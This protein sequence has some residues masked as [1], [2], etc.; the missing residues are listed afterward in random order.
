[1]R[2]RQERRRRA[3]YHQTDDTSDDNHNCADTAQ[4]ANPEPPRVSGITGESG[5]PLYHGDLQC[6]ATH[7]QYQEDPGLNDEGAIVR[8]IEYACEYKVDQEVSAV[9]DNPGNRER[10]GAGEDPHDQL[11]RCDRHPASSSTLSRPTARRRFAAIFRTSSAHGRPRPYPT[12][13]GCPRSGTIIARSLERRG[14][15][16]PK[17]TGPV[18]GRAEGS[19]PGARNCSTSGRSGQATGYA[20]WPSCGVSQLA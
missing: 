5:V 2:I 7:R 20:R 8:S 19:R 10:P 15:T 17:A 4:P 6:R 9:D 16:A 12:R 3:A 18:R 13:I 14:E 1:M 11:T